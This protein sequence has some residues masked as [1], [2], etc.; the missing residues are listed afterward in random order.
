MTNVGK[1][2]IWLPAQESMNFTWIVVIFE[3]PALSETFSLTSNVWPLTLGSSLFI[4][5]TP[6][7]ELKEKR[8]ALIFDDP[9]TKT[10]KVR[11]Q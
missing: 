11:V 4:V 10:V 9:L 3:L 7:A 2:K 6:V 5:N 8:A 1:L